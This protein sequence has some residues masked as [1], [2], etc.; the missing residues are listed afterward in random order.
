M[1]RKV[2]K[3]LAEGLRDDLA[4]LPGITIVELS[5]APPYEISIE[6]SESSLRRH[7]LTFDEVAQAVRRSSVD[8]PGGSIKTEGGEIL[9][10]TSGEAEVA[11]QFEELV[12]RTS[13]DGTR[14]RLG[15][16]ARVMDGFAETDQ[17]S[18]FD[19]KPAMWSGGRPP[20]SAPC[21]SR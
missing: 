2:L 14:L 1:D 7:G 18:R 5:N 13:R 9:L 12:L 15:D 6:V 16:V 21:C 17:F 3:V 8:L 10:R 4:A 19:G 20:A 11:R